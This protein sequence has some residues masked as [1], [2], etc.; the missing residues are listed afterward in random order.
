MSNKKIT[1]EQV[2]E[3]IRLRQAGQSYRTIGKKH[4]VDPRTVKS[5]VERANQEREKEHW[6]N[7]SQQ[8]D[9]KYLDEHYRLLTRIA[10]TLIGVVHT[11]TIDFSHE[12]YAD[13][14]INNALQLGLRQAE[15]IL[16]ERGLGT[17][18]RLG[19]RLF[20]ALMEHEPQ[21]KIAL[22]NWRYC[23]I[24]FEKMR[25]QLAQ[26][27]R[28]LFEQ[29]E[30]PHKVAETLGTV[31]AGDAIKIRLL[32]EDPSSY[33]VKNIDNERAWLIR[34]NPGISGEVCKGPKREVEKA[35]NTYEFVLSQISHEERMEPVKA[36]YSSLIISSE[37]VEDYVERLVL[38]GR[39]KGQCSLCPGRP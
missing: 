26:Q 31:V 37:A 9:T 5:W 20:E 12:Q 30:I 22:D 29:K 27:A 23:W 33:E 19:R 21:L 18:D 36:A 11:R 13:V 24:R 38:I 7:V 28:G 16:K 39:P 25:L 32:G 15:N 35:K 2:T 3:F 14:L 8:V 10:A 6:E 17:I 4:Q 1:D 34:T